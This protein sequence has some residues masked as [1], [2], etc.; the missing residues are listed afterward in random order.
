MR[1]MS[2]RRIVREK[3]QKATLIDIKQVSMAVPNLD[4]FSKFKYAIIDKAD[5][6]QY[7]DL[8]S[9]AFR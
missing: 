8:I 3:I 2:K 6:L 5:K 1:M 9:F 4:K 7:H